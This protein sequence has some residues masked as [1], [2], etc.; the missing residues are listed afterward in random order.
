MK[1][2][3]QDPGIYILVGD[4]KNDRGFVVDINEHCYDIY[5][6]PFG[7]SP[8]DGVPPKAI[9]M[10]VEFIFK[11][12]IWPGVGVGKNISLSLTLREVMGLETS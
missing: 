6:H 1:F 3:Q 7:L 9:H 5:R 11:H 12:Y 4:H 10:V 8:K 2:I